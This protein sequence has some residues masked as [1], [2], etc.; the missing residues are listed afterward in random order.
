MTTIYLSLNAQVA[1]ITV[2][3]KSQVQYSTVHEKD[4]IMYYKEILKRTVTKIITNYNLINKV[5][6]PF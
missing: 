6:F 4:N 1:K 3:M 5:Y 2:F